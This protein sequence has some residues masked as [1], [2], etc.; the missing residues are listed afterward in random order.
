MLQEK[1]HFFKAPSKFCSEQNL[2]LLAD[3]VYQVVNGS[4]T[5]NTNTKLH[6]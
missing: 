5:N 2:M 3:E 4:S 6:Q 1:Q